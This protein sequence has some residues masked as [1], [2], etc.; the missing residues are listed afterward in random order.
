MSNRACILLYVHF[1]FNIRVGRHDGR[2]SKGF[3][4][5]MDWLVPLSGGEPL[6]VLMRFD[7]I[8]IRVPSGGGVH[9]YLLQA[10]RR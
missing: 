6:P 1:P 5:R 8:D 2:H 7:R 9:E 4:F 3:L 10:N